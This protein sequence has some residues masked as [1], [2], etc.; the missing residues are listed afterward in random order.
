MS[1]RLILIT[2]FMKTAVR[3]RDRR[4]DTYRGLLLTA[5]ASLAG[6]VTA[7]ALVEPAQVAARLAISAWM[8]P[9]YSTA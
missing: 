5:S 7:V 9:A 3:L 6:P 2:D 4:I 1:F 8:R